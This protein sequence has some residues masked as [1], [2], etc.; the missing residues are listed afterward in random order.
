M[1]LRNFW[2]YDFP[3]S[4][5]VF[6]VALP[7]C[8]GIALA[9]GAPLLSGLIAGIVGGIV[10]GALSGSPISVSGPAAGLTTIV[11]AAILDLGSFN[12]FLLSVMIAGLIQLG[13][14][15]AKAG[16]IG[17]F[18]P[19]SVIK[20]MLASIGLILILKQIP[21]AVGYDADFEGDESFFQSD[22]NNTFTEIIN[23]LNFISP[24]AVIISVVCLL[25]LI[26]WTT[27]F[28]QKFK[29]FRL[30]PAP[31]VVVLVGI[32]LN[33]AFK[34]FSPELIIQPEHLV[35][36]PML[37][38]S[39]SADTIFNAPAFS[40][41]LNPQVWIVAITIALVASLETLLS[42]EACDKMDP[43]HR[44]TPLNRELKAQGVG[45]LISGLLGGLPVT[46][47]IVRS[48]AN[49]N[50]GGR[51]KASAISHGAILLIALL[52]I[53]GLLNLI[54]LSCLAAILLQVGFKLTKPAL[55]KQLFQKGYSQFLPF[56]ITILAIL[57]TNLL[58]GVFFG[59]IVALFF[60]LKTNFQQTIISVSSENNHLIKFSKD[61]SF[62]HKA[63][64]RHAL[65]DVPENTQLV[66]DGTKSNF[67]DE[68][69]IETIED[70]IE[71]AKSKQIA[72]DVVGIKLKEQTL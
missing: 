39:S 52:A 12:S 62:M 10:I 29:F 69:I 22:G 66:I 33:S 55:Y 1:N 8:L 53:P 23:A 43:Q 68:D 30:V 72:V 21:H 26:L 32:L 34:L 27:R 20:G 35:S 25:I 28:F 36:V 11:A 3:A 56:I 7:L 46:S 47:V 14:G 50:A 16:T 41:I 40:E 61:V 64:L 48:S 9:S 19:S 57:F 49:V 59:I 5:V 70:F 4:V 63:S 60:I 37:F 42:I 54:P 45:N 18:V 15:F 51:S 67:I 65:R 13:L 17:H 24:G 38:G 6:L 44:I 31:L 71:M 2:P 58:Q